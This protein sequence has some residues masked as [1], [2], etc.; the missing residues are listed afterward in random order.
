MDHLFG[1]EVGTPQTLRP[2]VVE[3]SGLNDVNG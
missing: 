2:V 1:L 3:E